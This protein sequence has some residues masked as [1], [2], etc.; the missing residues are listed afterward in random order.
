[1]HETLTENPS[2]Q[3]YMNKIKNRIVFKIK[4]GYK[5]E[6]LAPKTI[7]L[8]GSRKKIVIKIKMEKTYQN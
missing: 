8:L 3:I 7:K 6:L 5:L 2:V 4:T 1:M